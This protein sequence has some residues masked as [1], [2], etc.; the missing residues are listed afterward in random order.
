[1]FI[2][3]H[4]FHVQVGIPVETQAIG[5]LLAAAIPRLHAGARN[6]IGGSEYAGRQVGILEVNGAEPAGDFKR[7]PA[8][9]AKL[10]RAFG[11]DAGIGARRWIVETLAAERIASLHVTAV[12][13]QRRPRRAARPATD[14]PQ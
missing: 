14:S 1:M 2:I 12:E 9:A 11:N 3:E 4:E 6:R 7:T 10:Q 13:I 5:R 8:G